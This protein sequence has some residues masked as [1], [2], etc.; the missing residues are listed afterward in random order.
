MDWSGPLGYMVGL[1]KFQDVYVVH[2]I[3]PLHLPLSLIE[4]DEFRSDL[5]FLYKWRNYLTES[6][7]LAKLRLVQSKKK[8]DAISIS[9]PTTPNISPNRSPL[10]LPVDVY[11]SP[12]K[13]EKKAKTLH[14]GFLFLYDIPQLLISFTLYTSFHPNKL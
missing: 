5:T 4:L 8:Y 12:S 11:F 14:E 2:Y 3:A 10:L 13:T 9:S 1:F 6:S 7:Q